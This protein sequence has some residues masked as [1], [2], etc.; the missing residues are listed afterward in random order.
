MRGVTFPATYNFELIRN[1]EL[2]LTSE[3]N[4]LRDVFDAKFIDGIMLNVKTAGFFAHYKAVYIDGLEEY[5]IK[6]RMISHARHKY[7]LDGRGFISKDWEH[8][9]SVDRENFT[10]PEDELYACWE[11]DRDGAEELIVTVL[12]LYSMVDSYG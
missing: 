8:I 10:Q 2:W 3:A 7:R 6:R 11:H 4:E 12:A 1:G 5:K 9:C